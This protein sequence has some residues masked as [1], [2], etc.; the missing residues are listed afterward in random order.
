MKRTLHLGLRLERVR[1]NALTPVT[2]HKQLQLVLK[3]RTFATE[4]GLRW[5][6]NDLPSSASYLST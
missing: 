1:G 5:P 6:R 4:P 2:E 3:R